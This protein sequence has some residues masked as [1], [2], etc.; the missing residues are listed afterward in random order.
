[1]RIS[2]VCFLVE[3]SLLTYKNNLVCNQYLRLT[4]EFLVSTVDTHKYLKR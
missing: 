1:M 3:K 2:Y 4:V